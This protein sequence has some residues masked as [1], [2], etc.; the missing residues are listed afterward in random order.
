M[1]LPDR[2]EKGQFKKGYKGG[3]GRPPREVEEE[4]RQILVS[5]VSQED[6]AAIVRRAVS[7]AKK[8]DTSAR[9]FIADYLIGPPIERKE[10]T[11]A[12]GPIQITIVG[13]NGE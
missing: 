13:K 1:V 4:Y 7:D 5:N 2:N 10:L 12:D 8:G 9:K 6:W 11:G 3:P